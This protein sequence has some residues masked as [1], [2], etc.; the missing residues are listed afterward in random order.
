MRCSVEVN[1]QALRIRDRESP[2]DPQCQREAV[3]R[4]LCGQHYAHAY[5][6][7]L[8]ILAR[9]LAIPPRP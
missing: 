2:T 8:R 9:I 3:K 6:D 1:K 5:R 4:G 7:H